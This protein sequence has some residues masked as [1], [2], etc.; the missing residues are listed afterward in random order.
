MGYLSVLSVAIGLF[1]ATSKLFAWDA[2]LPPVGQRVYEIPKAGQT[3]TIRKS[4]SEIK[5]GL[6][7]PSLKAIVVSSAPPPET[8]QKTVEN[9]PPKTVKLFKKMKVLGQVKRPQ[10]A[11]DEIA[12]LSA[13]PIDESFN[14]DFMDRSYRVID[15]RGF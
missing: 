8:V 4:T 5:S 7:D 15:D 1:L 13:D 3:S 9:P 6:R 10:V 14:Q 11:F 12:P 2:P